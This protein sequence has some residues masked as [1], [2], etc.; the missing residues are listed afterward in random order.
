[1]T[2][3]SNAGDDHALDTARRRSVE[4]IQR[5][6]TARITTHALPATAT[7]AMTLRAVLDPTCNRCPGCATPQRAAPRVSA[8]CSTRTRRP[9]LLVH[10][11][12]EQ[13]HR[14][15]A[16]ARVQL[17]E[18][19]GAQPPLVGTVPLAGRCVRLCV[20]SASRTTSQLPATVPVL[21]QQRDRGRGAPPAP[22][23]DVGDPAL[24]AHTDRLVAVMATTGPGGPAVFGDQWFASRPAPDRARY[25]LGSPVPG[26]LPHDGTPGAPI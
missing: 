13:V 14:E 10:R 26:L 24:T 15:G 21:H 8:S 16:E 5:R 18:E 7:K 25:L 23:H 20:T 2:P 11:R 9:W 17:P 4:A 6:R 19:G 1:M 12:R 3:D 22:V